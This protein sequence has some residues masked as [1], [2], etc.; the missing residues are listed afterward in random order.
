MLFDC[1]AEQINSLEH[2]CNISD[3]SWERLPRIPEVVKRL[4]KD[5]VQLN[6]NI[7]GSSLQKQSSDPYRTSKATLLADIHRVRRYFFD[8]IDRIDSISYLSREAVD[9]AIEEVKRTYD[10]DGNILLNIQNYLRTFCLENR[11]EDEKSRQEKKNNWLKEREELVRNQSN[12]NEKIRQLQN[13]VKKIDDEVKVY[14]RRKENKYSST[15][16]KELSEKIKAKLNERTTGPIDRRQKENEAKKM[17]SDHEADKTEANAK[18][19]QLKND[20]KRKAEEYRSLVNRTVS[21]EGQIEHLNN[22]LQMDWKEQEKKLTVKYGRGLL[23]FG[24]PGT[25]K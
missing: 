14:E 20:Y 17:R 12:N 23:L 16:E 2:L 19:Q 8:K 18:L 22:L 10:D 1:L 9:L 15:S 3:D 25:G 13:E 24:P 4:I 21:E 7:V 5:Y 6:I 11:F